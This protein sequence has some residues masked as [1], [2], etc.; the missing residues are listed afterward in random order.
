MVSKIK[1]CMLV[2]FFGVITT[3]CIVNNRAEE[4]QIIN[5]V[6]YFFFDSEGYKEIGLI[7]GQ[8]AYLYHK[9]ERTFIGKLESDKIVRG[10]QIVVEILSEEKWLNAVGDTLNVFPIEKLLF[11][12]E[13]SGSLKTEY[14]DV[15]YRN[16]L[17]VVW[18]NGCWW[19]ECS[20][21]EQGKLLIEVDTTE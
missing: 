10:S 9:Q 8:S 1:E 4:K 13:K 2:L 15:L 20:E 6:R 16:S 17:A 5:E 7:N 19:F 18:V 21:E 14:S 11:A 3:S 12:K